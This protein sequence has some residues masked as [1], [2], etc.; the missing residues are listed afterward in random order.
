[1]P[2]FSTGSL[3]S[4][5]ISG[6]LMLSSYGYLQTTRESKTARQNAHSSENVSSS[7]LVS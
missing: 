6:T 4:R 1:M 5:I 2:L 3:G 7:P